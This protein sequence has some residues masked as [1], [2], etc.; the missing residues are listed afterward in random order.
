MTSIPHNWSR[1]Q[2]SDA[3][4]GKIVIPAAL[5]NCAVSWYHHNLQHPGHTR[6]EK[7]LHDTLY[8]KGMRHTIQW[9]VKYCC[10]CQID[11]QHKNQYGNFP[12]KLV[13]TIINPW[14]VLCLDLIGP[15]TLRSKDGTEIN[16]IC[17]T[18]I[19][20]ASSWFE[21]VE[22]LV[23]IDGVIPMDTQG[24]RGTKTQNNTKLPHFGKSS[25]M[26]SNLVNNTWFSH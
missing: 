19:N 7:T 18:M 8:W 15:F 5:Q 2:T 26:I 1:I 12:T 6:L 20:L 3:K 23:T 16:F 4:K 14:E 13:V 17:L 24:Q 25:A 11:K 10:T 9:H 21:I 22:L